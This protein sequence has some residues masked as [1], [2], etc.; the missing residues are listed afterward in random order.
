MLSQLADIPDVL[1]LGRLTEIFKLDVLLE[2]S[3]RRICSVFHRPGRMPLSEGN[4]PANQPTHERSASFPLPRSG[5][6]QPTHGPDLLSVQCEYPTTLRPP[7]TTI[8]SA[9]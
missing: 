9:P 8:S 5:S 2:L 1:F 3:D 4:L 7:A 6:V